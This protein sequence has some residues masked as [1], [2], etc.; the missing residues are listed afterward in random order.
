[1]Q[2]ADYV[3]GVSGWRMEKGWFE[4]NGGPHGPVRIGNLEASVE[5]PSD[6]Q[7]AALCL[8]RQ[9][10]AEPF[11]VVD[12]VTYIN[13]ALVDGSSISARIAEEASARASADEA[14][15]GR[16]GALEAA[17]AE[18]NPKSQ[19]LVSSE[20]FA[21]TMAKNP[22][23]QY[24]CTG[25]GLGVEAEQKPASVDEIL[26]LLTTQ[27]SESSLGVELQ[28]RIAAMDSVRDVIRQELKPGGLLHRR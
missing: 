14:L 2:S 3:P 25:I 26:Q 24:V 1:M 28:S 19:F 11:I 22:A 21:V 23:G 12:G 27:I 8:T 17:L 4:I 9:D 15:A 13:Q 5:K 10:L 16:T 6:D 20:R 18:W 7:L